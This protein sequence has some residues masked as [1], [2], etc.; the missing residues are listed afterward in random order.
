MVITM[1]ETGLDVTATGIEGRMDLIVSIP[2]ALH[3]AGNPGV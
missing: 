1:S 3:P 2:P